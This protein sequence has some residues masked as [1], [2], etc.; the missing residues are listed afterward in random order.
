MKYLLTLTFLL[1]LIGS[2]D[3]IGI[4]DISQTKETYWMPE[5]CGAGTPNRNVENLRPQ[6]RNYKQFMENN[7]GNLE[8]ISIIMST[9]KIKL[10]DRII[11][12]NNWTYLAVKDSKNNEII[13]HWTMVYD[14]G[15]EIRIPGKRYFA[16]FKYERV[17]S[18]R[19][20]QPL[21]N[22]ESTD[23]DC[24]KTDP[25]KTLIGWVLHE[26]V[27]QRDK[28]K[29][30]FQW[31]CFFGKKHEEVDVSSFVI[32][33]LYGSKGSHL[34][35]EEVSSIPMKQLSFSAIE[36]RANYKKI[37]ISTDNLYGVTRTRLM[38]IY[39]NVKEQI[40][41]CRKE[42]IDNTK[43]RLTLPIEFSWGDPFTND[44]LNDDVRD[45]MNCGS[46]YSISTL[47]SLQK[48]FEIWF[49]KKQ[50]KKITMPEL[51]YQSVLSCSPY[52][53]GCDGGFPF[54]VGKQLYEF[55]ATTE[56]VMRYGNND[57]I[58]CELVVGEYNNGE[59]N[60][61]EYNNGEYNNGEYN[62]E[63]Y[64]NSKHGDI[65]YASDYN[66]INGCYECSN[67]FDMM[68][69]LFLNGPIV[70]A[71]NAT[72][73]LLNLYN[74]SNKNFIYD[75]QIHENKICDIPNQGFNGW[76]QTNHAVT[77]VGWGQHQ[78]EKG[79]I[80]KYW[81]LRNTWGITWGYKG[82]IKYQR[83]VNLG[84]IESQAVYLD[85]DF[86]RGRGRDLKGWLG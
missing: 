52:N 83:G 73:Q 72:P 70:A 22:K 11:P 31:G 49:L 77:I 19:C 80:V 33:S 36:Q 39:E 4:W 20:P 28:E 68:N 69:E 82:Y 85:P 8:T 62:N 1:M 14:E 84:G 24:Y 60:N 32:H 61:G 64:K 40:Y 59:Y 63:G 7:Y 46:C 81:I 18:K 57:Y 74:L 47:Y 9:E 76:Q 78:N 12:R 44:N 2:G 55:G 15:F 25:T 38:R 56:N 17:I 45:Q 5:N 26:Q 53:Q 30:I 6:I 48:R 16:F 23:I 51:S 35:R 86:N 10:S 54:L 29:K 37:R 41:G 75:I 43:I 66:Y 21:E 65:F 58:K 27:D 13:G 67:E 71:I 79:T 50:N 42:N 34:G 3:V